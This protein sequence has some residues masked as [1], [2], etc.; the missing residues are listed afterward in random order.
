MFTSKMYTTFEIEFLD[1]FR[2]CIYF[3]VL[4]LLFF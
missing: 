3:I 1:V 2:L 4:M